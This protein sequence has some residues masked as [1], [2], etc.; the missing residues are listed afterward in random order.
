MTKLRLL[1]LICTALALAS[2]LT[3]S[4]QESNKIVYDKNYFQQF[5]ITTAVDAIKRIPGA[6]DLTSDGGGNDRFDPT[7]SGQKRGF[8][9][10]MSLSLK[11]R[12]RFW[13]NAH[14][15]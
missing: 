13:R 10:K 7:N 15:A 4:A 3:I 11:R 8:G 5:N 2:S 6:E 1:K 12:A 14:G 9:D